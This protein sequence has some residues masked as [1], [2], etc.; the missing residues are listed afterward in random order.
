M[1]DICLV[2]GQSNLVNRFHATF[3][4]DVDP[5]TLEIVAAPGTCPIPLPAYA[6]ATVG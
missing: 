1:I 6:E 4:T 2:V 5:S 3:L